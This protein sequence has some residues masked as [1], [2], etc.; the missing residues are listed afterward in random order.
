MKTVT[1]FLLISLISFGVH[2]S[3]KPDRKLALEYLKVSRYEQIANTSLD[4]YS[5]QL[6]KDL[7]DAERAQFDKMMQEVMG[8]EATKN[9]LADLVADVYT[10]AE[11]K[12]SI[13]FMKTPLGASVA[14]KNDVL[15]AKYSAF[16]SQNLLKFIR[17]HPIQP[18]PADNSGAA[19]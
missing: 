11:L 6:F 19:R 10:K 4:T 14:A 1:T 2:A 7:P 9:Q 15:S 8:W 5:Q 18:D 3:D 13:A 17:E 12:A 16:I